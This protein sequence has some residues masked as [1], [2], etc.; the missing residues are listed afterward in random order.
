MTNVPQASD[1]GGGR[2]TSRTWAENWNVNKQR[3]LESPGPIFSNN[4]VTF[5]SPVPLEEAIEQAH[6]DYTVQLATFNGPAPVPGLHTPSHL[7]RG[8]IP[9]VD[10][11]IVVLPSPFPETFMVRQPAEV[12]EACGDYLPVRA[13]GPLAQSLLGLK[14][15]LQGARFAVVFDAAED[16]LLGVQFKHYVV[17]KDATCMK[18][19][20]LTLQYCPSWGPGEVMLSMENVD[21]HLAPLVT[22]R[23]GRNWARELDDAVSYFRLLQRQQFEAFKEKFHHMA[24][25]R[26][27]DQDLARYLSYIYPQHQIPFAIQAKAEQGIPLS[28]GERNV[29]EKAATQNRLQGTHYPEVVQMH[30]QRIGDD[31]VDMVDSALALYIAVCE[32]E[33][34]RW[35]RHMNGLTHEALFSVETR[36]RYRTKLRAFSALAA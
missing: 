22:I 19:E 36:S 29:Y 35:G 34:T 14:E 26:L 18:D 30:Y 13:A 28:P 9:D 31:N 27:L 21:A 4:L 16:E 1:G 11:S 15:P 24:R 10:D 5:P 3:Y 32:F 6:L 8:P 12:L 7:A 17:L 25:R 2:R 33:D 20:T 23:R